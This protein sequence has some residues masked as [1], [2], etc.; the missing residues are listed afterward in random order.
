MSEEII[1]WVILYIA[2]SLFVVPCL[3]SGSCE[4][5]RDAALHGQF[6]N[7]FIVVLTLIA[8]SLHWAVG[9]LFP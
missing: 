6:L 4:D 3:F 9:V 8:L 1:A 7:L 5:Y 2:W